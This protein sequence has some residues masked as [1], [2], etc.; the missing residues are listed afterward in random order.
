MDHYSSI[1]LLY[2]LIKFNKSPKRKSDTLIYFLFTSSPA[3]NYKSLSL[4]LSPIR[5]NPGRL[6]GQLGQPSAI[7]FNMNRLRS[8]LGGTA[9]SIITYLLCRINTKKKKKEL[10]RN[11]L[12]GELNS[13]TRVTRPSQFSSLP[14]QA[15]QRPQKV[16]VENRARTPN[17][18]GHR[19]ETVFLY[20]RN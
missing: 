13:L 18:I 9:N 17:W 12:I 2:P 4:S 11:P 7:S 6:G 10:L 15:Y 5:F 19:Y 8:K 3:V 14:K 20:P 1:S 16:A